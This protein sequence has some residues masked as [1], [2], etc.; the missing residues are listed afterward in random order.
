M[1][2][3]PK[4]IIKNLEA[5]R[6]MTFSGFDKIIIQPEAVRILVNLFLHPGCKSDINLAKFLTNMPVRLA[7][8]SP[9]IIT[10]FPSSLAAYAQKK[11][12]T[13]ISA[14]DL[15]ECFA[16]DHADSVEENQMHINMNP[17]YALAHVLTVGK[18]INLKNH[19]QR[20]LADLQ[21]EICGRQVQFSRVLVPADIF[22]PVNSV[23]FHHF[24]VVVA[25]A[26]SVELKLLAVKL[27]Q[28]QSQKFFLQKTVKQVLGEH[29]ETIDYA[30]AAFFRTDMTSR[31]INES[32]KDFDFFRLWQE[33]DLRSVKIP[34]A[35]GVV[36]QS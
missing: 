18:V 30:K 34:Q 5:A 36:F 14:A 33:E 2:F 11:R 29:V 23:V 21:I 8:I 22:A 27:Q 1:Q 13:N 24:G 6:R 17:S 20:Q 3:N 15:L 32:K 31:I 10:A 28:Q 9:H 7:D 12:I 4:Q 26:D 25:P 16:L 35:E 19:D